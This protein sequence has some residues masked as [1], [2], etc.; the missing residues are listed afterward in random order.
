MEFADAAAWILN[1]TN[2]EVVA[3]SG[4]PAQRLEL[5]PLRA[6]LARLG[7]PQRGRGGVHLTGSNGKGSTASMIAAMLQGAGARVGLYTSPH[8]HTMRERIRIDGEPI[9]PDDFAALTVEL[10]P[11]AAATEAETGKLTVFEILTALGFMA[12]RAANCDWQVIEVGLG[13]TLDATNVL[14]EKQVCVF[15]PID[16]EHTAIL[17][18][19]VAQIASDKAGILRPGVRAVMSLQREPAAD[20]LRAAAA[21]L[22][23][24]LHEVAQECALRRDKVSQIGRAHV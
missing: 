24:T 22:G 15:T 17:G 4:A 10:M 16:L 6:L 11:H 23:V 3:L 21:R 1:H 13:G 19:T 8:L 14:D 5:R 12:F 18:N 20:A 2:H 7:E 9:A